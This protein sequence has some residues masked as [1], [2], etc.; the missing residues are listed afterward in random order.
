METAEERPLYS[1]KILDG[2]V[3]MI[4]EEYPE[5]DIDDLM[6]EAGIANYGKIGDNAISLC[7]SQL[8][9]FHKRLCIIT[10]NMKIA[11]KAGRYVV[12]SACMG[13]IRRLVLPFAGVRQACGMMAKYAGT[14]TLASDYRVRYLGKNKIEVTVTSNEKTKE[15]PFQ[16]QM[17]Q[18]YFQGLGS[19]F[20]HNELTVSHPECASNGGKVCRYELTW[21]NSAFPILS[22]LCLLAGLATM[23][24]FAALW[25]M[26]LVVVP[27]LWLIC[28][29][30]LFLGL[31]WAAQTVKSRVLSRSL[32]GIQNAGEAM[33]AQVESLAE[34][35]KSVVEIGQVLGIEDAD[36]CIFNRAAN[37]AGK[38]LR[39]DRI[40]I[41]IANDEKT[42]L[43]YRGGYGFTPVE[44][45]HIRDYRICLEGS[46][47]GL[48][49][50]S[51]RLNKTMLVNDMVWLKSKFP[52][53]REVVERIKPRSFVVTPIE[54]DGSPIGIMIAGNTVTLRKL[55]N[56]DMNMIMGVAQQI[57]SVYRRQQC[58]TQQIEFKRQIVQLQKMEALGVL[59]GGIAHDFNNILSPILGYTDLCL[60]ICPDDE[61]MF[62]YL[63]RVKNASGRAQDLVAQIL[64]FSRQGE[65]EYIRCHPGPIIKE[66]LKLLSASVPKN[67]K[68]ETLIT[69][70]LSPIM[71][72][73]T[74]IHQLVMNLCTN[75]HHAMIDKG[76]VLTVRLDE[77]QIQERPLEETQQMLPGPYLHLQV[78]DTGHGMSQAVMDNIFE[79]YFTT[80]VRGRG[81][82]MG[83]PIIK[84]IV[85]RLKGYIFVDSTEGQGSCFDLYLPQTVG[86]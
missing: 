1:N 48:V 63:R 27:N 19:V 71:A 28:P 66:S 67:I 21:R 86:K 60:S 42:F 65:K 18:G 83:L 24:S 68:I 50:E 84:G 85:A 57:G 51:F 58:E 5:I 81:T 11:Q 64:A 36:A 3:L 76:G 74:Q 30:L 17:R 55:D 10:D 53:S 47:E 7:Q 59:A 69:A 78:T 43:S 4:Q 34:N 6:A 73:P 23:A 13:A 15:A 82:G 32:I 31:G 75:A 12:K 61:K 37:I 2:Y 33:R 16:C 29:A 35:A 39:Y 40:A 22:A 25:I 49:Y 70:D 62:K 77:I 8:N 79:P 20:L 46:S 9:R 56:N 80:K 14:L 72:D 41:M 45:L 54:V 38:K 52:Q 26:P 44:M